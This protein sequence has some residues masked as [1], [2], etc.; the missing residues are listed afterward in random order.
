M[1]RMYNEKTLQSIVKETADAD[2]IKGIVGSLYLH[3]LS[4][5]NP[6]LKLNIVLFWIDNNV[7]EAYK[8]GDTFDY[9]KF[10]AL[11]YRS[12]S[13]ITKFIFSG[14]AYRT[15]EPAFISSVT[16]AIKGG[17]KTILVTDFNA[18]AAGSGNSNW[19]SWGEWVQ[20]IYLGRQLF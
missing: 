11:N 18:V 19:V 15:S 2:Y 14:T 16:L 12:A 17:V 7:P 1:D 13:D 20:K 10:W 4:L 8:I 6:T 5:T 3:S 9:D